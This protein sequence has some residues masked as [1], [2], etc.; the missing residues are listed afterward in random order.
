[1][2]GNSSVTDPLPYEI[3]FDIPEEIQE[4]DLCFADEWSNL[5]DDSIV[6]IKPKHPDWHYNFSLS[7]I[8]NS[9]LFTAKKTLSLYQFLDLPPPGNN[10]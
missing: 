8:L 2:L 7:A 9:E 6:F 4:T 10:C 5:D 1:L 3:P